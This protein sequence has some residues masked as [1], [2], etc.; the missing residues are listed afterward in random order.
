MLT[1]DHAAK[2]D[3]LRKTGLV[4]LTHTGG[5][6][7]MLIGRRRKTSFPAKDRHGRTIVI[8]VFVDIVDAHHS[9]DPHSRD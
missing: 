8:D 9:A 7:N 4:L 6:R 3:V 5:L 1:V 2:V